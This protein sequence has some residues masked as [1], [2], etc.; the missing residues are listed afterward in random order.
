MS[1]ECIL[2]GCIYRPG[3]D[4][5]V[6]FQNVINSI[7]KSYN[8]FSKTKIYTEVLICGDF[9][10][11]SLNSI[12][13]SCYE[14]VCIGEKERQ[15]LECIEECYL[16]QHVKKPT[17]QLNGTK[18]TNILD[19]VFTASPFRIFSLVHMDPLGKTK[20]GHH[21]LNFNFN[22]QLHNR[23]NESIT[24]RRVYMKGNYH[25]FSKYLNEFNW[26]H[27]FTGLN[28]DQC[29]E[30][31]IRTIEYGCKDFIPSFNQKTTESKK[32]LWM[33]K[34]LKH[35]IRLKH[36]KEEYKLKNKLVKKL[37]KITIQK[38][39]NKI[40]TESKKN[41]KQVYAYIN[42]KL[43]AKDHI[44]AISI[45][46][47]EIS[48]DSQVIANQLNRF[49]NSVFINESLTNMPTCENITEKI[50]PTL[51]FNEKDIKKRLLNLNVHK[52]PGI[53]RIHPMFLSKCADS[54]ARPLCMIFNQSF[55]TGT[56][57]T[58]WLKAN[59]TP[60][61]KNGD[62]LNALQNN[63]KSKNCVTN[64][65]KTLDIITEAINCGK[66]VDVAFLDFSKAFDSVPHSR[67]LLKL[68]SFGIVGKL[69]QWCKAFLAN[70]KQRV[71]FR[72]F[73]SEWETVRSGV[74]QGS[75]L[76][77]LLFIIYINDVTKKLNNKAKLYAD[78]LKIIAVLEKN[79]KNNSLQLD[80]DILTGLKDETEIIQ[81]GLIVTS[82]ERDLGVYISDNLKWEDHIEKM[83]IEKI[84]Q[85]A[86][87]F[88]YKKKKD[89]Y[90]QRLEKMD[91]QNLSKRREKGDLIQ[92]Y[93]FM[94]KID[95]INWHREPEVLGRLT[96][97]HNQRLRRQYAQNFL[98][99]HHFFTNRIVENWNCL[100][101]E[102]VNA[103][104][105]AMER[106]KYLNEDNSNRTIE[107]RRFLFTKAKE[108]LAEDCSYHYA[109]ELKEILPKNGDEN[110]KIKKYEQ[111]F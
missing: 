59:I 60:I 6:N 23:K 77:P 53:N 68:K 102:V 61:F 2:C 84:Q 100:D 63:I 19:L 98:P 99:R 94:N 72:L 74:P 103:N 22:Y 66:C 108:L 39:E 97:G 89:S 55:L 4:D 83:I 51:L 5:L 67:L 56:L 76:G 11:P 65:L 27:E 17:F 30:S 36:L 1:N 82:L 109:C 20:R 38:Y 91:L 49:F 41:P 79:K 33:N 54:L 12:W 69:L 35:E 90:E 107:T 8:Y 15:F 14:S 18:L 40:A 48:T 57:P 85:K 32:S 42:S 47:N 29:Y 80:L 16:T 46:N 43:K 73:E 37:V 106:K 44:R 21:V 110:K 104:S 62:R 13:N 28:V 95:T 81:H 71:V 75:V 24:T 87:K 111:I 101:S 34:E 9:N 86:T 52:S 70:R 93:K 31:F 105:K 78:D 64:L 25:E 58:S 88:G 3:S 45:E 10:F 96:R 26:S 7:K 50:C 92:M